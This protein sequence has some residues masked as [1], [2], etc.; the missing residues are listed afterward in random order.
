MRENGQH[1][2]IN[3]RVILSV[4][5]YHE[6]DFN[7][8]QSAILSQFFGEN[9]RAG[10]ASFHYRHYNVLKKLLRTNDQSLQLALMTSFLLLAFHNYNLFSWKIHCTEKVKLKNFYKSG[11]LRDARRSKASGTRA[12]GTRASGARTSRV[13]ASGERAS[14]AKASG[15]MQA[16]QAG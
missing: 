4:V 16:G 14:G 5:I 1:L 8:G 7:S 12:S 10:I 15:A 9:L 6:E 3:Q 13:M 11:R 2:Y